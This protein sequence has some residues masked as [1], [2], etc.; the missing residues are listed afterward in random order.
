[1]L[2]GKYDRDSYALNLNV[3]LIQV[4]AHVAIN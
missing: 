4:L 1:M 2:T 3:S